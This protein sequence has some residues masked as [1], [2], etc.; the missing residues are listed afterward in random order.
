M[1]SVIN[2]TS[3][4]NE[5]ALKTHLEKLNNDMLM[6]FDSQRQENEQLQ[7]SIDE[8]NEEKS[9]LQVQCAAAE[10]RAKDLEDIVGS[11]H[12]N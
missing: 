12:N 7:Q 2:N 3:D 10:E 1:K 4:G 9:Q 5:N 8:L 6:A 11:Y